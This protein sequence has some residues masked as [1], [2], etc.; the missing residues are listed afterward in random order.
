M[1]IHHAILKPYRLINALQTRKTYLE[2]RSDKGDLW[3]SLCMLFKESSTAA[4]GTVLREHFTSFLI[5]SR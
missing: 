2:A 4:V 3:V 5:A 1:R